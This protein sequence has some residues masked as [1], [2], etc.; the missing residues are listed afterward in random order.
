MELSDD[1]GN[2]TYGASSVI[3][4]DTTVPSFTSLAL[5]ADTTDGYLSISEHSATTSLAGSLVASG[6][7]VA[8]YAVTTN[9][10][11]CN[12]SLTYGSMP[13]GNDSGVSV[14]EESYKVCVKLTDSAGN[15]AAYGASGSFVALLTAPSCSSV[16]LSNDASDGFIS[17]TE[18][19]GSLAVTSGVVGGSSSVSTTN[20]A[21]IASTATCN[22]SQSFSSSVPKS[23]D[24][25]FGVNGTY[26]LCAKVADAAS[27]AGYCASGSITVVNNSITFTSIDLSGPASDG[28]ISTSDHSS[29]TAIVSNLVGSNYD[30]AKY[31]VVTAATTCSAS[32]TYGSGVPAAN[33]GD[34]SSDGASYKVCVELSDNAGNPKA[35]GAS[36]TFVYDNSAPVF[37]SLVLANDASDGYINSTEHGLTTD[38]AGP[39]VATG[40]TIV[41]YALVSNTTTCALPLTWI[42]S[43][44]K[45]NDTLF[46][47]VGD[48]KVCVQLT[49]VAGNTAY[50]SSP[51]VS[52]DNVAPVFTGIALTNGA[53]DTY[54]NASESSGA[55]AVVGSLVATGQSST[56]YKVA[57][58][59]AT[60]ST[61]S[62]YS[63]TVPA[64][65][66]FT[67]LNGDYKV[68]VQ[69]SDLAG[70]L[71]YGASSTIHVDTV[72]PSFS[73]L[74]LAGDA[75][76]TYINSS[77]HSTTNPLV[78]AAV[79]SGQDLIQYVLVSNLTACSTA[80]GWSSSIPQSN[81]SAFSALGSYKVCAKLSDAAGNPDAYGASAV[82]TFD[83]VAPTFTSLA[84]GG[85]V[86]DGYLNQA[87]RSN[88]TTILGALSAAGYSSVSY[89]LA[90]STTTCDG[91]L[92][93]GAT[94]NSN[95]TDITSDG[96]YKICVKLLD[97]AGNQ[98][99]GSSVGFTVDANSPTFSSLALGAAVADGYL[100]LAEHSSS[101][102]LGGSLVSSGGSSYSYALVQSTTTCSA[103]ITYAGMPNS[104]D[105]S[106]VTGVSYKICAKIADAAGNTVYGA[107]GSFTSDFLVPSISA[108]SLAAVVSDGYLNVADQIAASAL[109][110]SATASNHD[111][112]SY[113]V[114]T[115]ST[116]CNASLTYSASVP[117]TDSVS[118]TSD[119]SWKVCA[120]A[121][122]NA[123]NPDAFAGSGIFT[124]DVVRPSSSVTTSGTLTPD[125][126][127][128]TTTVIS[129]SASDATTGLASL[130]LSI[131]EGSGSC[132][133]PASHDFSASCPNWISPSGT[134]SWTY[135]FD[136]SDLVKGQT[137]TVSAKATDGAGN[138]QTSYGSGTFSFTA[139][140]GANLWNRDI[141]Y[142]HASGDDRA[143][144]GALDANGNL[145]V[146]GYQTAGDKNWLI[147]KFS[148]R[149]IE[150]TTNWNKD[151]GDSGVDEIARSVAV[152]SS[153]NVYVVGSRW[154]GTDFDW[155]IKK[156]SS[157]GVEDSA[158][159]DML[160]NSGNGNDEAMGVATDSAGNVYVV[161]Y[162]RNLASGT[163]GEDVWIKKFSSNGVLSCEQQLDEGAANL[164]DRAT[165]I[166]VNNTSSKIYVAG[167]KTVAGP[168][169]RLFVKRL[170]MSD[171]SIEASATGNS[172]GT[173]DYAA[174]VKIDNAGAV[175]VAGVYS[176]PDQDWWIQKYTSALAL[177]A[178]YNTIVNRQHVAQAIGVDSAN[179]IYVGG[180]KTTSGAANSQ[181]VW[182]RQFS[183]SLVENSA[184]NKIY[185]SGYSNNDQ[186]TAVVVTSGSID[187]DNVYMIGWSTNIVGGSSGADW[188]IKKLAGP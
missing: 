13:G 168:D 177:S 94:I 85:D 115:S 24:A 12:G 156:Y 152:D 56:N 75:T 187:A 102:S 98:T 64:G 45:A 122:D 184:W 78:S 114:V 174:A 162:G 63:S 159:W 42:S 124:R 50:A 183:S 163:S 31:A 176:S 47:S 29:S 146:V 70:N 38:V 37:T 129:G 169:Q 161:G 139:S 90:L 97:L 112:I 179:R 49:D 113:A 33:S 185:D 93:Y 25:V 110:S 137:Y 79:G 86:A 118:F 39:L 164:S 40:Q 66:A 82:I 60:C 30:T 150:D 99:Y 138:P 27:Q 89:K 125:S 6:Y 109:T 23:N 171:C 133:D 186:A 116:T 101:T 175:Y 9:A 160:I 41:R 15:P 182:L 35:Y 83:N 91:S 26:K 10:T 44:P 140:E 155:M 130:T 143:L 34:I 134:T 74:S 128:G 142:D 88:S 141:T 55:S 117:K 72:A 154:N 96:T 188:W 21:V 87:E 17:S 120:K 149:G 92:S 7:D 46:S 32:V 157:S 22:G 57:T 144:A 132:F 108:V 71:S 135:T 48:Y 84:L 68:C 153:G 121:S 3:H 105:G 166:A 28:Y 173:A 58:S 11:T 131:Q 106:L 16:A 51:D 20:Y 69:L 2:K 14:Q 104:D 73:S 52:F 107:S 19:G 36:S 81:D 1:A 136:D 100:S 151:V 18:H 61:Q 43:I 80:S 158:N 8:E 165:S 181:D 148:R 62:S 53:S 172:A 5:G 167:Y 147:K 4:V 119:G 59:A 103:S 127:L 95:S 77:E 180:Y 67:G 54:I 178:E 76:D 126:T 170:R 65:S 145:Y 111:T 123:G